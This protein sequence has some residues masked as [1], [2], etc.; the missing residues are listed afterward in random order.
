MACEEWLQ[1]S[2]K[3]SIARSGSC[4]KHL[5]STCTATHHNMESTSFTLLMRRVIF[6]RLMKAAGEWQLTHKS[7][8]A[9]LQVGLVNDRVLKPSGQQCQHLLLPG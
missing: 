6:S 9:G 4:P 8:L 5:D 7:R 1:R 2:V 3:G